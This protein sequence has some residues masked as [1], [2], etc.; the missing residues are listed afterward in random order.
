MTKYKTDAEKLKFF[1]DAREARQIPRADRGIINNPSIPIEDE[2]APAD[3]TYVAPDPSLL[4]IKKK[5]ELMKL[6]Q[7][8]GGGR[9]SSSSNKKTR[10]NN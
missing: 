2:P 3:N 5:I 10:R 6:L 8:A 4:E 9:P 1:R 7:T